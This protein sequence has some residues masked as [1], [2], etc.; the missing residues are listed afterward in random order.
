MDLESFQ[1]LPPS[2]KIVII[3][4]AGD[5][6]KNQLKTARFFK[7]HFVLFLSHQIEIIDK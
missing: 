6:L 1:C 5:S 2:Q 7:F 3:S 4:P